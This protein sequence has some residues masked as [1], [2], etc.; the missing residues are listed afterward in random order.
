MNVVE[1][2]RAAK[3]DAFEHGGHPTRVFLTVEDGQKLQFELITGDPRL[4]H[5]I[6]KEGLRHAVH[7]I[8]GLEVIWRSPQFRV[9]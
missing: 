2:I 7:H 5:K 6:E 8:E 4:G 3:D 1:R 9:Q